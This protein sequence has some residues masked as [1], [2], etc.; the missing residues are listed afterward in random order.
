MNTCNTTI[1][2]SRVVSYVEQKKCTTCRIE[3][4]V[5]QIWT[6]IVTQQIRILSSYA[7]E[8]LKWPK[9]KVE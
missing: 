6:T 2:H 9:E 7:V 5:G 8:F 3:L 1:A 4:V